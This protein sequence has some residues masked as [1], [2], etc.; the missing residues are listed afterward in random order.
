MVLDVGAVLSKLRHDKKISQ[1]AAAQELGISQA[2]LSHYE[3]GIREPRLEFIVRA[4]GYYGVSADYLFGRT[5]AP[6]NPLAVDVELWDNKDIRQLAM[7]F[8]GSLSLIR[9]S[10]GPDA[11]DAAFRY[12]SGALCKLL[13]NAGAVAGPLAETSALPL[14]SSLMALAEAELASLGQ[15]NTLAVEGAAAELLRETVSMLSP[16]PSPQRNEK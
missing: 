8:S 10:L 13:I 11:G 12:L 1:R 7:A 4:C 2:L 14:C 5:N 9:R 15:G 16:L 6:E 3:N